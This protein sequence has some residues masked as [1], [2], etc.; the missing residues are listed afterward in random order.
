MLPDLLLSFFFFFCSSLLILC[1]C[2]LQQFEAKG[3][4]IAVEPSAQTQDGCHVK[5]SEKITKSCSSLSGSL[6]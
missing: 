3:K 4:E 6:P 2:S 5:E 1:R